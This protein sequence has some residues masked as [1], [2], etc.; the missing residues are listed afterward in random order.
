MTNKRNIE[1]RGIQNVVI[2]A[3]GFEKLNTGNKIADVF[4]KLGENYSLRIDY[5]TKESFNEK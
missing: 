3:P 1:R 2:T 5:N 4:A